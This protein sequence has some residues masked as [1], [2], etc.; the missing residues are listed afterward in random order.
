[1]QAFN[2]PSDTEELWVQQARVREISQ[3]VGDRVG[4]LCCTFI[5]IGGDS[6]VALL[7]GVASGLA[8][9]SK[10]TSQDVVS[11]LANRVLGAVVCHESIDEGVSSRLNG[12]PAEGSV[13]EV[14]VAGDLLI[15][16]FRTEL[17]QGVHRDNTTWRVI[18]EI[19]VLVN[20][21]QVIVARLVEIRAG[22]G[23]IRFV[24]ANV[25]KS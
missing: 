19:L 3:K 1:M 8:A 18:D 6:L 2:L 12:D 4:I 25:S 10:P 9:D 24:P 21:K 14:W 23:T 20:H 16:T 5:P 13:E 22:G 11:E 17:G 7:D 15:P